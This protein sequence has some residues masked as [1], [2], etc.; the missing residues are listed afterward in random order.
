[1]VGGNLK[2]LRELRCHVPR[3]SKQAQGF[4]ITFSKPRA[5]IPLAKRGPPMK[6]PMS[7][8]FFCGYPCKIFQPVIPTV[9]VKV[10]CLI[11]RKI[12]SKS[13]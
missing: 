13:L 10:R 3:F 5:P 2:A 7:S 8:V 11:A 1:M 6:A 9:A 12:P 4:D